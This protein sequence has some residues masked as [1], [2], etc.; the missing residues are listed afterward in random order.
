MAVRITA[1]VL[2]FSK[3]SSAYAN[4]FRVG[5]P[6]LPLFMKCRRIRDQ[7]GELVLLV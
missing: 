3:K 1:G 2:P 7:T 4:K 6:S 5:S